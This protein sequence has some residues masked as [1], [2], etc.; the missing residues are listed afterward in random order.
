M[1][2]QAVGVIIFLV[3]AYTVLLLAA[4]RL[5]P[6]YSAAAAMLIPVLGIAGVAWFFHGQRGR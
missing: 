4:E 5:G 6:S 2:L 3:L 1:M